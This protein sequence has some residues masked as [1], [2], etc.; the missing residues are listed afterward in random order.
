[1]KT[2]LVCDLSYQ[3]KTKHQK[4]CSRPCALKAV[5]DRN[6][7]HTIEPRPCE[8][9]GTE[10]RP[11]SRQ[12]AGRFCSR[13]CT[14]AGSTG[15]KAAHWKGGRSVTDSGYVRIS[16]A[17]HPAATSNGSYVPEHR[18]VMEEALGR[19]LEDHETV[20]HLNGVRDDNRIEN[21]QLRS[22]RHGRGVVHRCLDCGSS[23]VESVPLG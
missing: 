12:S 1:M 20:H 22:G 21:L 3:P 4:Y 15:E 6:V 16:K 17:G 9:C 5:H 18:L 10:F 23:N 14:Y 8:H 7:D 13:P 19:Y 2:C 11:K